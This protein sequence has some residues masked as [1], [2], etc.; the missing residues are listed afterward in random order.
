MA[1]E[2]GLRCLVGLDKEGMKK[3]CPAARDW[4]EKRGII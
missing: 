3:V 2:R 1:R 4:G